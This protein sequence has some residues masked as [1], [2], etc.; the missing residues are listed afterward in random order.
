MDPQ[1]GLD[2][3]LKFTEVKHKF[4]APPISAEKKK[5]RKIF[6]CRNKQQKMLSP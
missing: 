4:Y 2:Q 1:W 5:S 6:L 3:F